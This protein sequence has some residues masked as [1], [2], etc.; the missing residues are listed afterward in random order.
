M[1]GDGPEH[2]LHRR[3]HVL[4]GGL[5]GSSWMGRRDA[6]AGERLWHRWST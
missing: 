1:V 2:L 6:S 4:E 3:D 5:R